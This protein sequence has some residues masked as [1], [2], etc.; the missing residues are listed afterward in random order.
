MKHPHR[1]LIQAVKLLAPMLDPVARSHVRSRTRS[2]P[3][4]ADRDLAAPWFRANNVCGVIVSRKTTRDGGRGDLCLKFLVRRKLPLARLSGPD[5][6]PAVW[7]PAS[8]AREILT[9]IEECRLPIIARGAPVFSPGGGAGAIVRPVAPG[10]SI[11]H[12]WEGGG[13][14]GLVVRRDGA[15]HYLSC[16][17]V[18]AP[19]GAGNAQIGDGEEQPADPNAAHPENV[20]ANLTDFTNVADEAIDFAIARCN[21]IDHTPVVPG[22]GRPARILPNTAEDFTDNTLIVTMVGAATGLAEGAVD[23]FGSFSIFYPDLGKSVQLDGLVVFDAATQGGDSGAA[24][25][26][27]GSNPLTVAGLYVGSSSPTQSLFFP[28]QQVFNR[29]R[30]SLP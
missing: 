23:G 7:K 5:V 11:G 25:F 21:A 9:D 24:V 1:H 14:I 16:A 17:H 26:V 20:V 13:T 30:I 3:K 15:D 18:L 10:V 6:I 12:P 22:I 4:K 29:M 28:A 2:Q 8:I 19:G 27:K